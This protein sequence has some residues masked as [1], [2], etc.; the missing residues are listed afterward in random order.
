MELASN[1]LKQAEPSMDT[2]P[3]IP[4]MTPGKKS[5]MQEKAK[6]IQRRSLTLSI[7]FHHPS[8]RNKFKDQNKSTSIRER[9]RVM[10]E[11]FVNLKM[12]SRKTKIAK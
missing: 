12:V 11:V 3:H 5:E 2:L 7:R 1:F 8:F 9:E 4:E 6:G 10:G